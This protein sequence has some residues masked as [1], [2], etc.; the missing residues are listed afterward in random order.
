MG[1]VGILLAALSYWRPRKTK[2]LAYQWTVAR[3]FDETDYTL[4]SHAAMT[5]EG[6]PVARLRKS[7]LVL[8]NAGTEALRG[9]D[10]VPT[11]PIRLAVV[12]GRL[13]STRSSK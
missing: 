5:F 9:E 11:D 3:Y 1:V 4:P 12:N 2:I 8:W 6:R 10:V 7:T 13:L